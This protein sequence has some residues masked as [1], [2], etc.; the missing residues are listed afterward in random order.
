MFPVRTWIDLNFQRLWKTLAS[1]WIKM[2]YCFLKKRPNHIPCDILPD[3]FS[4]SGNFTRWQPMHD[5]WTHPF[6]SWFF[7]ISWQDRFCVR[8]RSLK[9]CTAFG[10][11]SQTD[12]HRLGQ[13]VPWL[14]HEM[15]VSFV[16]ILIFIGTHVCVPTLVPTEVS[17]PGSFHHIPSS[18]LPKKKTSGRVQIIIVLSNSPLGLWNW[19]R[20][21]W[22]S[23]LAE[24]E[25]I[26]LL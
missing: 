10:N 17:L 1:Q 25:I 8:N 14:L 21:I 16:N 4:K 7:L 18:Y 24:T 5:G 23:P 6:L 12:T 15:I 11:Q 2:F 26:A 19:S 3:S 13:V 22:R 20:E 9:F